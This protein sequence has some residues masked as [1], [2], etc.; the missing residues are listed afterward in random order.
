LEVFAFYTIIFAVF[1][2]DCL[3]IDGGVV[4]VQAVDAV[5]TSFRIGLKILA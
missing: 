2:F 4:I 3:R 1:A 5:D